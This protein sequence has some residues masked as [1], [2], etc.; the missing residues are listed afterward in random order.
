[1]CVAAG[2]AVAVKLADGL[3]VGVTL[4]VIVGVSDGSGVVVEVIDGTTVAVL[5]SVALGVCEGVR[6]G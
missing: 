2:D 1:M 6:V 3:R 4:A 5:V